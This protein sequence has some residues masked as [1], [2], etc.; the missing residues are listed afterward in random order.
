MV[1]GKYITYAGVSSSTYGLV[2][3]EF[4]N[5]EPVTEETVFSPTLT[6]IKPSLSKKF[7]YGK[8]SYDEAPPIS[9]SLVSQTEITASNRAAIHKWLVGRKSFKPLTLTASPDTTYT[10]YAVFTTTTDIFVNGHYHGIRVEGHL[11]SPYAFIAN[12][13]ATVTG[14]TGTT[15]YTTT[16]AAS[17]E[18]EEYVYPSFTFNCSGSLT[19]NVSLAITNLTD[20]ASRVTR[21]V[22][23]SNGSQ[24]QINGEN[25]TITSTVS[26]EGFQ[27]FNKVWPRLLPGNNSIQ[28]DMAASSSIVIGWP[29]YSMLGF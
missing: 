25:R 11:Q 7:Y 27:Q 18:I 6:T 15:R 24:V 28:I 12:G 22:G 10:Y 17:N 19:G 4:G 14:T 21:F 16:I 8:V 23:L 9:L 29:K 20:N 13:T 3:A 26:G 5:E 2:L 1:L